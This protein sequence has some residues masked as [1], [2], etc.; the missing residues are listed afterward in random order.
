[1]EADG[2]WRGFIARARR[3]EPRR[4][5]VMRVLSRPR[6]VLACCSLDGSRRNA[7]AD[8]GEQPLRHAALSLLRLPWHRR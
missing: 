5:L 1:M 7:G 6:E 2:G 8:A 4:S 3:A